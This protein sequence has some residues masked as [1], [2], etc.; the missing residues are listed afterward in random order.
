M[1]ELA[2]PQIP[3]VGFRLP[4]YGVGVYTGVAGTCPAIVSRP[5]T[6]A[7]RAYQFEARTAVTQFSPASD[8]GCEPF[9]FSAYHADFMTGTHDNKLSP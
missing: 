4:E 3:L 6:A 1:G 2:S 5:D 9:L 8:T 7:T